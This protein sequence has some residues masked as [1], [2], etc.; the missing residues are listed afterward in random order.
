MRLGVDDGEGRVAPSPDFSAC[1]SMGG[2]SPRLHLSR[3]GECEQVG[4]EGK[5]H[6]FIQLPGCLPS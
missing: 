1:A 3:T 6:G 5:D 2:V 4:Q